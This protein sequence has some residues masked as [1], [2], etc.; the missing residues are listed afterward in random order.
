MTHLS[1]FT[2][3]FHP[4]SAPLSLAF[5]GLV[6]MLFPLP[7]HS[8]SFHS[9]SFHSPFRTHPHATHFSDLRETEQVSLEFLDHLLLRDAELLCPFMCPPFHSNEA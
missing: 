2:L 5:I 9:S 8:P 6:H 4:P 3:F 1:L 7:W